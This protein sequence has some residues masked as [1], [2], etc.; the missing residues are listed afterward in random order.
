[1]KTLDEILKDKKYKQCNI[2][3]GSKNGSSFWYCGRANIIY[4]K[5]DLEKAQKRLYNQNTKTISLLTKRLDHLD[6]I[7]NETI[8][9]AK[10]R[11]IKNWDKYMERINKKKALY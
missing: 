5:V 11:N 9:N 8:T 2:K 3:V 4:S 6:Q 7:Y 10:K 1:M